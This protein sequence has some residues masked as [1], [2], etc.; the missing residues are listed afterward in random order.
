MHLSCVDLVSPEMWLG[1]AKDFKGAGLW[2]GSCLESSNMSINVNYSSILS[3][4]KTTKH[5]F[6]TEVHS[7][8]HPTTSHYIP[9]HPTTSHYTPLH[10]TTSHH[11]LTFMW[12]PL[13]MEPGRIAPALSD[14]SPLDASQC[15]PLRW[16]PKKWRK[17][18]DLWWS[19]HCICD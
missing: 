10:P 11:S 6:P 13:S 8:L 18:S 9:L 16:L 5:H 14:E 15:I 2:T 1:F 19:L 7:P 3:H 12:W 17:V 4:L